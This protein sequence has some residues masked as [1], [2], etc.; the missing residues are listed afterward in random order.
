MVGTRKPL[1]KSDAVSAI[2]D[3]LWV[4]QRIS[5][6]T[7]GVTDLARARS[8]YGMPVFPVSTTPTPG[9]AGVTALHC[10]PVAVALPHREILL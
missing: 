9:G 10:G 3:D 5:L 6:V 8:F 1:A 4:D 7:L 2:C